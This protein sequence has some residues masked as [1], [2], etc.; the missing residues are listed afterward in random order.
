MEGVRLAVLMSFCLLDITSARCPAGKYGNNCAYTCN[1]HHTVCYSTVGCL[2]QTCNPGWSGRTCQ[3]NNVALRKPAAASSIYFQPS[4][5]VNGVKTGYSDT[6]TC[7][8]TQ[9]HDAAIR[10]AWW[11]VD[12]GQTTSIHYVSIYFRKDY[13][14]R[15]NG[16]K[17]Y[18]ADTVFSPTDGVNCY[19][20]IG[21]INGTDIPDVLTATCSGRGRYLV[22]YTT[23]VNNEINNVIVPVL[24]FCEVEINVCGPGTF[25]ADCDNYCHCDGD[26]C[27]YVSGVCPSGVCLPGFQ[28]ERCDTACIYGSYGTNCNQKCSDRNCKGDNSS[29]DR[30]TGECVGGCKAGGME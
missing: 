19:N 30:S 10:A 6:T 16:I 28:T 2:P 25:G 27:D 24:D 5:A 7:M 11:I 4:N 26:V 21:N 12:L 22:L 9:F 13:K 14:V 29:C 1:C 8:H 3:K 18:I 20:V 15:R 17:I 23:T